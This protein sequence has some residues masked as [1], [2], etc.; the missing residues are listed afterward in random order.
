MINLWGKTQ[1]HAASMANENAQSLQ[2]IINESDDKNFVGESIFVL[3]KKVEQRGSVPTSKSE[4]LAM[5]V[6]DTV[7]SLL[8]QNV[9]GSTDIVVGLHARKIVV[10]LDLFD[11][12]DCGAE[13]KSEIKMVNV[14]AGTVKK[15]CKTWVPKGEH[16]NFHDVMDSIGTLLGADQKGVWGRVKGVINQHFSTKDKKDLTDMAERITQ[17][18]K[19]TR[20]RIGSRGKK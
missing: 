11:W 9:F 8:M 13:E 5:G 2:A 15:S 6:D 16:C 19:A 20:S 12:E 18:Y 3:S 7:A 17:F 10:A 4:L 1:L 14:K